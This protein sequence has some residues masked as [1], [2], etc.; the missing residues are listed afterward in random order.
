MIMWGRLDISK[1]QNIRGG[2]E[3]NVGKQIGK[4]F[5][6]K[7]ECLL[8]FSSGDL[9]IYVG[10]TPRFARM[11]DAIRGVTPKSMA[12][13]HP[14]FEDAQRATLR[15]LGGMT[16]L[17]IIERE[18]DRAQI[19]PG[20]SPAMGDLMEDTAA[21]LGF[22]PENPRQPY[23]VLC[24]PIHPN[25]LTYIGLRYGY[26]NIKSI[27]R[28][29]DGN[30]DLED[31]KRVFDLLDRPFVVISVPDENPAGVC[32]PNN[33]Y[34]NPERTGILDLMK[35]SPFK[36]IWI[37]DAIYQDFAWGNGADRKELRESAKEN[38]IRFMIMHS[39]SKVNLMP[40]L[41]IGGMAY[42]GPMDEVGTAL[43]G[44][45]RSRVDSYIANG[46]P[47]ISLMPLIIAYSGDEDIERDKQGVLAEVRANTERNESRL[48]KA[49]FPHFYPRAKLEAAFYGL[50]VPLI[51]SYEHVP[52]AD[53]GYKQRLV[54]RVEEQLLGSGQLENNKVSGPWKGFRTFAS[55][56]GISASRAFAIEL[57]T[58][59]V[60]VLA[61]DPFWPLFENDGVTR[62]RDG[63]KR[64]DGSM[65]GI[66]IRFVLA[67]PEEAM[68]RGIEI[69]KEVWEDGI[70][71]FRTGRL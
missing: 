58:H 25:W 47:S 68:K 61:H 8:D 54:D 2:P 65:D 60:Q 67:A 48:V 35:D 14:Y 45:M 13:C 22:Q 18:L 28:G 15:H 53:Q 49:G 63:P 40:G 9:P 37:W 24:P 6:I 51:G 44:Y 11:Y 19:I 46:V 71:K 50:Q 39:L 7:S 57:A 1:H 32:T 21:A 38:G 27:K 36:S 29:S 16:N 5:G 4:A 55:E 59:G 34:H 33:F 64:P 41:R 26:G 12:Y 69:V 52:W 3:K 10:D 31:A 20:I 56:F 43:C 17:E 62:F 23:F 30:P 66:A 42:L 70:A